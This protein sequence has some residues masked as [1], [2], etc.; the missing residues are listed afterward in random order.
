[1]S[2]RLRGEVPLLWAGRHSAPFLR[3]KR[4]CYQGRGANRKFTGQRQALVVG[5]DYRR[6]ARDYL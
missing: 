2:K 4:H 6:R 5:L 3:T 1:M